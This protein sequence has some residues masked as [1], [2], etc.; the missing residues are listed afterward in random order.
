MALNRTLSRSVLSVL[1]LLLTA[2]LLFLLNGCGQGEGTGEPETTGPE[3][4]A[5]PAPEG[6]DAGEAAGGEGAVEARAYQVRGEI[7][8]LPDPEDPLSG[9]FI[10]H[11][12]ID[13]FV[14]IDNEVRGMDSMTM[15]FPV[16]EDLDFEGVEVGDKVIFTL[17]VDYEADP[18]FQVTAIEP[19]PEDTEIEFRRAQPPG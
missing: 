3:T 7:Q 14:N 10:R 11:E 9:L 16:A 18:Q 6:A 19:L 13:D 17:V 15:P 8:E 2:G 5:V 4:A 1:L 12:A